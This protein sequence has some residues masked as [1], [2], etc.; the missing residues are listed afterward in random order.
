MRRRKKKRREEKRREEK[1]RKEKNRKE[2]KGDKK[3]K[4]NL[5]VCWDGAVKR[6]SIPFSNEGALESPNNAWG[7]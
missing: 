1:K 4:G 7:L 3:R 6:N 5:L 2:K